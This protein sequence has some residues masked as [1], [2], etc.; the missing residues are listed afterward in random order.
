MV[1][2]K[3]R[4]AGA[5]LVGALLVAMAFLVSQKNSD[6][7]Q[8]GGA[9]VVAAPPRTYIDVEDINKDGVPDWQDMLIQTD[10]VIIP[11]ASTTY[12]EPTTLTGKFALNFFK[13][14]ARAKTFGM[15]GSSNEELVEEATETLFAQAVDELFIEKDIIIHPLSDEASLRSYGNTVAQIILAHPREGDSEALIL[16]DAL[17]YDE[18][19]RIE[20]LKPIALSYTTM[21]KNL[22]ETPVPEPYVKQHLDFINALSAVREDIRGMELIYEDPLYTLVRMK[23]YE[24]D[25]LGMSNALTGLFMELYQKGNIRWTRGEP[26]L[27]LM[28]FPM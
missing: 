9:L 20:E 18:P 13:D 5:F 3:K 27:D 12:E 21:I 28:I 24:D 14:F 16:Q 11:T 8:T 2:S 25:V 7:A 6:A 19:E 10:P 22:L 23:R 4:I 1:D 17:R 15:F 26:V